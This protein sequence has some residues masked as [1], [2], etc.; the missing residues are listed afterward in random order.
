[1]ALSTPVALSTFLQAS[2]TVAPVLA[3]SKAVALPIPELAPLPTI[4]F[5]QSDIQEEHMKTKDR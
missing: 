3:S 1:M 5:Y 4:I 2:T